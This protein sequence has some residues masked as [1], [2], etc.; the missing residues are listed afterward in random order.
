MCNCKKSK[1]NNLDSRI[2]LQEI[3]EAHE[4]VQ[5]TGV[6]NLTSPNWLYLYE[7]YSKAYPN[8]NGMPSQ[9]ELITILERASQ[10]QTAYR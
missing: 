5:R 10:L 2:V 1:P 7:V 4:F 9:E 8:S 3:R 6:E